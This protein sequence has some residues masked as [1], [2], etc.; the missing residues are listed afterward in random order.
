MNIGKITVCTQQC[1]KSTSRNT[2]KISRGSKLESPPRLHVKPAFRL[3]RSEKESVSLR[4]SWVLNPPKGIKSTQGYTDYPAWIRDK[5]ISVQLT[6]LLNFDSAVY[7]RLTDTDLAE[8]WL[9]PHLRSR[10]VDH[11]SKILRAAT[12]ELYL[13]RVFESR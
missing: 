9:K 4:A 7:K 6:R 11:S 10:L 1:Y 12:I 13:R 3:E 2:S 8:R 5:E